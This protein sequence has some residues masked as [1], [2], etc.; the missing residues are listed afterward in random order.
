M[1]AA[2]VSVTKTLLLKQYELKVNGTLT[3][4]TIATLR[5]ALCYDN[6]GAVYMTL[7][8]LKCNKIT[9]LQRWS[10]FK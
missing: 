8:I 1:V 3:R 5:K 2:R 4:T 6:C 10:E 7:T 9:L